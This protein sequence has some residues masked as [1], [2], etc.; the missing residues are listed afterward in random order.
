MLNINKPSKTI[1][2]GVCQKSQQLQFAEIRKMVPADP[3][4]NIL[5]CTSQN[6]DEE[7][8]KLVAV[9]IIQT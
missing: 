2:N 5:T 1:C 7:M 8:S 4:R 6:M 9:K 3:A